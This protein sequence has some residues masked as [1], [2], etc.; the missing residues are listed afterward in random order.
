MKALLL[1]AA[2]CFLFA[3]TARAQTTSQPAPA[4][5][6]PKVK[7]PP[8]AGSPLRVASWEVRPVSPG[9]SS[10]EFFV[11]VE[12]VGD[13][14]VRAYATRLGGGPDGRAGGCLL[15]NVQAPG[16]VLRPGQRDGKSVW[17]RVADGEADPSFELT[18]DYVE[19]ADDGA[20]G[21]DLCRSA[22]RLDGYRAGA[23][24]MARLLKKIQAEHGA[25]SAA[26]AADER[27]GEPEPPQGRSPLWQ[28]SFRAGVN[29]L[30]ERIRRAY[31][32]GG[33]P[34][35]ETALRRPIDASDRN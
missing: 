21:E 27:A 26:R 14:P 8:Q 31:D 25:E 4:R 17:Q 29:S 34:E 6:K 18:V 2:A 30:R 15:H 35:V 33:T 13:R 24:E 22:E 9:G 32:E 7:V 28:E 20:W 12:N 5:P 1:V 10:Y 16:K 3:S 11:V 19:F 23:K